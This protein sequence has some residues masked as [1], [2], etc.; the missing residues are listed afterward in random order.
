VTILAI[1]PLTNLAEA[2][3]RSPD[4]KK[5]IQMIY[6]MGGAINVPG[7]LNIT[8]FTTQ[9]MTAEWNIYLDPYAASIVF[10]AKIPVSL[11]PLDVTNTVP[12]DWNFYQKLKHR[13]TTQ[14]ANFVYELFR[15]N[16]KYL[17]TQ[18]WFFWDPLAAVLA[19]DQSFATWQQQPIQILLTPES[20][21]GAMIINKKIGNPI[22]I[23]TQVNKK[24]F[25]TL[26]LNTI[27]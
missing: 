22:R 18:K 4:I 9:N 15:H 10:S 23:C 19:T 7:N 1:G 25:E 2:I 13:H 24:Y 8:E 27:N 11:I 12:I 6:V 16:E 26:L 21:S 5:N 14:A 17:Q 20:Q 3:K